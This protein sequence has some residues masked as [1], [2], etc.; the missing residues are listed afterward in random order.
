MDEIQTLS[1]TATTMTS[2]N[3]AALARG[4]V[5]ALATSLLLSGCIRLPER[6]TYP[7]PRPL[8]GEHALSIRVMGRGGKAG[9]SDFASDCFS[10][11][12][13]LVRDEV[14]FEVDGAQF[15]FQSP[16][17]TTIHNDWSGQGRTVVALFSIY[18]GGPGI[19][20]TGASGLLE[21]DN[22]SERASAEQT[23]VSM[24]RGGRLRLDFRF[25]G[26]AGVDPNG[27]YRLT[28]TGITIDGRS[29]AVPPVVFE[30]YNDWTG[31][32]IYCC[33]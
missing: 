30:P 9:Q 24:P 23:Q 14:A 13:A 22:Q 12:T 6:I 11:T 33:P 7:A 20:V 31:F 8:G 15:C 32:G 21:W 1:P 17:P 5:L 28:V 10:N 16:G 2:H 26:T 27:R 19:A 4:H 3:M 18:V 29:I 25:T